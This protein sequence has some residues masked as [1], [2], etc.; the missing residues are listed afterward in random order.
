V[1]PLFCSLAGEPN[2]FCA[3]R[4]RQ[5]QGA[6][7]VVFTAYLVVIATG[8]SVYIAVGLLHR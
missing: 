1:T 7:R 4:F 2:E 3:A 5:S 8:L 6:V